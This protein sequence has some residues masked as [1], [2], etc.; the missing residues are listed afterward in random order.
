MALISL[1]G[2]EERWA[3]NTLWTTILYGF[4]VKLILSSFYQN[5]ES[6]LCLCSVEGSVNLSELAHVSTDLRVVY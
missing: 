6:V 1:C 4:V 5:I 2:M 3:T